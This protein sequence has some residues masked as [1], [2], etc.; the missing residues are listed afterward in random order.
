M[1][2]DSTFW[3]QILAA[4]SFEAWLAILGGVAYVWYKSGALT[5][6]GKAMEAGISGVMSMALGP[7]LIKASGYPPTLVHFLI[8]VGGFL[9]L[10]FG[11]SFFS[12]KAEL[13]AIARDFIRKWLRIDKASK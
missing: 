8:A 1:S 11:T 5:R 6:L 13:T 7:D 12:D 10:D 4:K 3:L 9:V 2:D